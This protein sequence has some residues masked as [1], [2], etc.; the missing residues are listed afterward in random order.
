[1]D[2]TLMR[3]TQ[4]LVERTYHDALELGVDFAFGPEELLQ[5]LHPFKIT[6]RYAASAREDIRDDE[7]P[8]IIQDRIGIGSRW[9]VDG[10]AD[11]PR[12]DP[13]ALRAVI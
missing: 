7:H 8:P 11:D 9:S 5:P 10:F 3:D 4:H 1:M 12:T 6:D 2:T 13:V